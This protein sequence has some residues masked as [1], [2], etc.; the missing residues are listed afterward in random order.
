MCTQRM[1]GKHEEG[2]A[3]NARLLHF[4]G[5]LVCEMDGQS[6]VLVLISVV[7]LFSYVQTYQWPQKNTYMTRWDK[8]NLDEILESKRLLHH[9]F[10]CLMGKGPCPPDGQELRRKL[11]L[12]NYFNYLTIINIYF[13]RLNL[14]IF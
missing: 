12:F 4:I 14:I 9:Y 7:L 3:I 5:L 6:R 10:R 2:V 13:V 8:V 1:M 11:F